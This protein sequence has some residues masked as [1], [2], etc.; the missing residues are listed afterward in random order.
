MEVSK[1]PAAVWYPVVPKRN[2]NN[3]HKGQTAWLAL[4]C[5]AMQSF[6][7]EY[8]LMNLVGFW[9]LVRLCLYILWYY[10]YAWFHNVV[11]DSIA[12]F[13]IWSKRA[14]LSL[15]VFSENCEISPRTVHRCVHMYCECDFRWL[16][17]DINFRVNTGVQLAQKVLNI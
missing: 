8:A 17:F 12:W 2:W 11:P 4:N 3:F 6:I 14:G 15:W 5:Q 16:D 10:Y 9:T 1:T 7:S 13:A